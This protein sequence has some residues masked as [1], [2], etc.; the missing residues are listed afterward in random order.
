MQDRALSEHDKNS[1][2]ILCLREGE[3]HKEGSPR[4]NVATVIIRLLCLCS[5]VFLTSLNPTILTGMP[6]GN[7]ADGQK[8]T[9]CARE[10]G[11]KVRL[12]REHL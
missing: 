4:N 12:E 8:R 9:W 7:W 10:L 11:P 6:M 5:V 3:L 1:I 2:M